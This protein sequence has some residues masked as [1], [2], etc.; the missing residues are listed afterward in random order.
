M[1]KTGHPVALDYLK[2]VQLDG[3]S[4]RF[5]PNSQADSNNGCACQSIGDLA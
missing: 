5:L 2:K 4:N 3:F 1:S